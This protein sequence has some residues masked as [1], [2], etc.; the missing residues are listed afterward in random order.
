V[1]GIGQ[2]RITI[3]AAHRAQNGHRDRN[4]GEDHAWLDTA[5]GYAARIVIPCALSCASTHCCAL[6]GSSHTCAAVV[7][8]ASM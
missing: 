4:A 2:D 7:S 1:R 8:A 5:D 3:T 6:T